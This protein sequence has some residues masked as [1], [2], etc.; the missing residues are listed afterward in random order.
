MTDLV[1]WLRA[2]LDEAERDATQCPH[3]VHCQMNVDAAADTARRSAA[4]HRAILDRHFPIFRDI[5]WQ[6][7]DDD[8]PDVVY[9]EVEVCGRC[10]PK[11]AHFKA[12]TEVPDWP[13]PDVLL[14]AAIYQDREGFDPSWTV[15]G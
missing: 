14:I 2:A 9:G 15:E 13:C 7:T 1:G 6:V 5:G 4:A 3:C 10:V 12:R 11:H 8:V